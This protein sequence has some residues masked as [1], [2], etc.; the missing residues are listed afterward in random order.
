MKEPILE[1]NVIAN[2]NQFDCGEHK[3]YLS[4][5][6]PQ[7]LEDFAKFAQN[8]KCPVCGVGSKKISMSATEYKVI[9]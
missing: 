9:E 2:V 8:V 5:H 1:P 7:S 6:L 4:L 3:F